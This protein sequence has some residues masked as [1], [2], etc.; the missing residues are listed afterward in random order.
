MLVI[1]PSVQSNEQ[2]ENLVWS[3]SYKSIGSLEN[4]EGEAEVSQRLLTM[5]SCQSWRNKRQ[6]SATWRW[7]A[8]QEHML[9]PLPL[10]EPWSPAL[11]SKGE[12]LTPQ[13]STGARACEL[14]CCSWNLS[15]IQEPITAAR[16]SSRPKKKNDGFSLPLPS[17]LLPGPPIDWTDGS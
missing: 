3:I 14:A 17:C 2:K 16:G 6:D 8:S 13:H 9:P 4:E 10:S 5:G 12:V 11:S 15:K 1:S 7:N